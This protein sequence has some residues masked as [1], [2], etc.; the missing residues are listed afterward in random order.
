VKLKTVKL[1]KRTVLLGCCVS[2]SNTDCIR[3]FR[4]FSPLPVKLS[5]TLKWCVFIKIKLKFRGDRVIY[6]TLS[7]G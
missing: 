1:P 3:V 7:I 2:T 4:L 6:L 5:S